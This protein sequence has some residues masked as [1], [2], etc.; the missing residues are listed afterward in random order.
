MCSKGDGKRFVVNNVRNQNVVTISVAWVAKFR[1]QVQDHG[2]SDIGLELVVDQFR[3]VD[4]VT[5]LIGDVIY[6]VS[7]NR[8][9]RDMNH[10]Q[11]NNFRAATKG[12]HE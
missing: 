1:H 3:L 9:K 11:G 7:M 10:L 12:P 8:N 2:G 5:C 6:T 4:L